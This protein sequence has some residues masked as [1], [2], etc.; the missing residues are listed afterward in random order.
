MKY[1]VIHPFSGEKFN[2][3]SHEEALDCIEKIKQEETQKLKSSVYKSEYLN[4]IAIVKQFAL[5]NHKTEVDV[6]Y[7]Y[8]AYNANTKKIA[9]RLYVFVLKNGYTWQ[10]K[11]RNGIVVEQYNLG[12]PAGQDI[13]GNSITT[14]EI[15]ER[16][17]WGTHEKYEA[18]GEKYD[19]KGNFVSTLFY[20]AKFEN[21][22][23]ELKILLHDF[24]Y[25]DKIVRFKI[26]EENFIVHYTENVFETESEN[27]KNLWWDSIGVEVQQSEI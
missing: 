16:Y 21:L 7:A 9:E 22:P 26:R 11:V 10:A 19:S 25:I 17:K 14:N 24:E 5:N 12:N 13:T 15:I 27:E 3:S 1:L 23:D 6:Q 18:T 4:E 20:V 2:F 8:S